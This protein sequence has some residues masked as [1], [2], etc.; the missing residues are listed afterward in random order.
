[1]MQVKQQELEKVQTALSVEQANGVSL[2]VQLA[3]ARERCAALEKQ[4]DKAKELA[5]QLAAAQAGQDSLRRDLSHGKAREVAMHETIKGLRQALEEEKQ[6][7]EQQR[8][9]LES[10]HKDGGLAAEVHALRASLAEAQGDTR[11]LASELRATKDALGRSGAALAA[12]AQRAAQLTAQVTGHEDTI[13]SLQDEVRTLNALVSEL[14]STIRAGEVA[15]S[16]ARGGQSVLEAQLRGAQR[17]GQL[18]RQAESETAAKL[19]AAEAIM[20]EGKAALEA[21]D[22]DI[23]KLRTL[24]SEAEERHQVSLSSR[25]AADEVTSG[26]QL[27]LAQTRGALADARRQAAAAEQEAARVAAESAEAVAVANGRAASAAKLLSAMQY[28]MG[29]ASTALAGRVDGAAERL[30]GRLADRVSRGM[31]EESER[32]D[33]AMAVTTLKLKAWES[34]LVELEAGLLGMGSAMEALQQ[35]AIRRQAEREREVKE[36]RGDAAFLRARVDELTAALMG[37]SAARKLLAASKAAQEEEH[38]AALRA[39]QAASDDRVEAERQK[40]GTRLAAVEAEVSR[41]TQTHARETAAAARQW[42]AE[43]A[44][45]A[46]RI[47]ELQAELAR[48]K[49]RERKEKREQPA[50]D[51]SNALAVLHTRLNADLQAAKDGYEAKLR[52]HTQQLD[53]VRSHVRATWATLSKLATDMALLGRNISRAASAA[54]VAQATPQAADG[55]GVELPPSLRGVGDDGSGALLGQLGGALRGG[56]GRLGEGVMALAGA[57][58]EAQHRNTQLEAKAASVDPASWSALAAELRGTVAKLLAVEDSLAPPCTCLMCLD[59]FKA[60][61]TLIPCGHTF[62]R[63]C[64]AAANGLCSECGADSPAVMTIANAPLDAI[65][66]KYELKRSALAAIQRALTAQ[67]AAAQQQ[68]RQQ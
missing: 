28:R 30:V 42:E 12:E 6:A 38:R 53:E 19:V 4:A 17:S 2:G 7:S 51:Q 62:C 48:A 61:V 60:P 37:E 25:L 16:A 64:L 11:A 9:Q 8:K 47:E 50:L 24:L 13:R 49:E 27:Q 63:R 5:A 44:G 21:R 34:Q 32:V 29:E 39:A 40:L 20:K 55:F 59:V 68:N 22:R 31:A 15:L 35:A 3:E 54:G 57:L 67:H 45:L 33:K 23:A 36:V 56:L 41:L 18:A 26:L 65:C 66:A 46:K 14:R 10:L 58:A 52:Q 1:M 43:R